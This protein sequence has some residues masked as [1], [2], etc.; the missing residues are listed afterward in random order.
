MAGRYAGAYAAVNGLNSSLVLAHSAQRGLYIGSFISNG[1]DVLSVW[2]P[3]LRDFAGVP[4]PPAEDPEDLTYAYSLRLT[5]TLLFEDEGNA[6]G[7]RWR[8]ISTPDYLDHWG[9][10][11]DG[12]WNDAEIA[13][14]DLD[15]YAGK[16]VNELVFWQR[17]E[18]DEICL[19]GFEVCLGR[20]V[21]NENYSHDAR[22][23]PTA[24]KCNVEDQYVFSVLDSQAG[25]PQ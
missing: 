13:D 4:P 18:G 17:E 3:S 23:E 24:V 11:E 9:A 21:S 1:T 25:D 14:V 15:S 12:V 22:N 16:P 20:V 10:V 7:E 5:P 8:I 6:R 2:G 19:T